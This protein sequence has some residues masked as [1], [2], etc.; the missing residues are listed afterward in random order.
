MWDAF[1]G[2]LLRTIVMGLQLGIC[3]EEEKYAK[4]QALIEYMLKHLKVNFINIIYE[5]IS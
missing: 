5:Y 3:R 4:K 1:E 2:G